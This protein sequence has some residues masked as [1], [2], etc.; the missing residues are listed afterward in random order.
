MNAV[1][2]EEAVATL[3]LEPFAAAGFPHSF[4]Q[5]EQ[6]RQV[7]C[8]MRKAASIPPKIA[9]AMMNYWPSS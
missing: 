9:W 5:A 3:V 8:A 6:D 4:L 2:I 1:E 7:C